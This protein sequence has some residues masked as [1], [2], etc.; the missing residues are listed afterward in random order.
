MIVYTIGYGGRS[1]EEFLEI[2]RSFNIELVVDVRRWTKSVKLPQFS[3][4]SLA[5]ALRS[6]GFDYV[7]IPELGGYRRFGI[8]V[9]DHGIATCFKAQGF[10]AYATYITM[11]SDV[12][13]FLQ[14]LLNLVSERLAVIMCRER[15]PWQC[16][17]KIL[18]DYLVAKG[19]RVLHIID[20]SKVIEHRL[21]KCAEIVNN[22]LVYR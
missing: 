8:D 9:E 19:F 10:R 22:E 6:N 7:W 16:H 12:K 1:L 18:A 2:L 21:S 20:R 15:I 4:E 13:P 5:L 14:K 11:R 17:R 3:G